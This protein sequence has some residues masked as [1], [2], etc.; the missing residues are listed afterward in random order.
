VSSHVHSNTVPWHYVVSV[1]RTGYP[2]IYAQFTKSTKI[3]L[4]QSF[5]FEYWSGGGDLHSLRELHLELASR[6]AQVSNHKEAPSEEEVENILSELKYNAETEDLNIGGSSVWRLSLNERQTLLN[7]WKQQVDKEKLSG[8]LTSSYFECEKEEVGIKTLQKAKDARIMSSS[9][10]VAITTTGLAGRWETLRSLDLEILICEEAAEV[11]EAHTLC[12]LFPTIQH[13]VF[14]GD[15]LQLRPEINE[16]A[17]TLET[18]AG[19]SYRLDESLLERLMFPRDM[20]ASVMLASRLNIQRRMH[21]EIANITRLTYPY[22]KDHSSVR[23]RQP[24]NG[25]AQRMFWWD[26]RVPELEADDLKS[27]V[28]LH[29][30]EMVAVLVEYLLRVGAYAQGQIAVLT[31]YTG[32]LLKLCQRLAATCDIWL[33]DKDREALLGE[34]ILAI[35]EQGRTTKDQIVISDML[36][37]ATVDAY[38]GEEARVIIL[39]TVRSGGKAGFLGTLNRVNVAC[40]RA[41]DGMRLYVQRVLSRG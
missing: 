40:S 19:G 41:R 30:V 1:L 9:S 35:G 14:I 11:M 24:T 16:Q 6:L 27:H 25:M 15:P 3:P 33:C 10:V 21:P 36:R 18:E 12:S 4:A 29:E 8:E 31:P 22:L 13:A 5:T 38:Q 23:E 32:Q 17:L 26:H 20:S 28:N 37:L 7:E 39:S 34:E 2:E